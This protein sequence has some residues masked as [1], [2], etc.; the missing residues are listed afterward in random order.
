MQNIKY[1]SVIGAGIMGQQIAL[2][3]ALYN[4]STILYDTNK[5][6]LAKAKIWSDEYLASRISKGKLT[7]EQVNKAKSLLNFEIDLSKAVKQADLVIEAIIE[8]LSIKKNVFQQLDLF[9]PNHA[10]LVSNSSRIASS[11]L[12]QVTN[13]QDKVANFHYFNP[14]LVME[15]IEI[16]RA[17]HTS[18]QTIAT[19]IQFAKDNHKTPI[20]LQQEVDGFVVNR[21]LGGIMDEAL[22]LLELGIATPE[23]IDLGLVKG[24]NHPIGPFKLMDLT[25][26]DLAYAIRKRRTNKT[27]LSYDPNYTI[28]QVLQ[29]KIDQGELGRKSGKGWYVY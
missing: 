25:G 9:A 5:E 15:L 4:F 28:P 18:K 12:A 3:A 2:N 26:I 23:E 27:D 10:I 20:V 14:A 1:V 16:V 13:R 17:P 29:N 11:Q 8:D 19:L 21:I 22:N 7:K 6:A 24:L